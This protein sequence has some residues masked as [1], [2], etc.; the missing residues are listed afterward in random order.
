MTKRQADEILLIE[1]MQLSCRDCDGEH[2]VHTRYPY[3][4]GTW[5]RTNNGEI[6]TRWQ[7]CPVKKKRCRNV[8]KTFAKV[9]FRFSD[10]TSA[11]FIIHTGNANAVTATRRMTD[12][13]SAG[14]YLY[15]EP[16]VG[17]SML[18]A[19]T[20]NL[21]ISRGVTVY[22]AD[23]PTL[24]A[25]IRLSMNNPKN[26]AATTLERIIRHGFVVIDD[27]GAE[28]PTD[29]TGE[30]IFRLL[31]TR[32]NEQLPTVVTSNFNLDGLYTRLG[33]NYVASRI[34]RRIIDNLVIVEMTDK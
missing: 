13:K 4:I 21:Y 6:V 15:G 28:K 24:L 33:G 22:F 5:T 17:K 18:A 1:E 8:K 30:Q 32:Y 16:G 19:I 31:N 34:C 7:D 12:G 23:T 14:V 10:V 20:A 25:S 26:E 3:T 29:W 11:D 2:C 9:P 27:L